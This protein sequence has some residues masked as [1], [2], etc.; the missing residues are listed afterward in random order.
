[1]FGNWKS[2]FKTGVISRAVQLSA[3]E[4][5]R[6]QTADSME[7]YAFMIVISGSL[8]LH[9]N[10]AENI[11]RFTNGLTV[12]AGKTGRFVQFAQKFP[13]W[14]TIFSCADSTVPLDLAITPL[15]LP[16]KVLFLLGLVSYK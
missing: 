5:V 6:E 3:F 11:L 14:L 10:E 2:V 4:G 15:I 1:M 13:N 7:Y 16:E 12:H 9:S 8:D